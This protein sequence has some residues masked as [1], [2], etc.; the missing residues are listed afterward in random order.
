M[1]SERNNQTCYSRWIVARSGRE[2]LLREDFMDMSEYWSLRPQR[3]LLT[4]APLSDLWDILWDQQ[5]WT[6]CCI[7]F[8]SQVFVVLLWTHLHSLIS[9]GMRRH[10]SFM[11][12]DM[13][14]KQDT[15]ATRLSEIV[16]IDSSTEMCV[17]IRVPS[18]LALIREAEDFYLMVKPSHTDRCTTC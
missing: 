9:P 18:P 3:F 5:K 13:E 11:T 16:Q 1:H 6:G 17:E 10:T 7:C 15:A 8:F 12:G 14:V 2:G 4:A